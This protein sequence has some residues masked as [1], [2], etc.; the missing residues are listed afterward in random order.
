MV[1]LQRFQ[2]TLLKTI[3]LPVE[4]IKISKKCVQRSGRTKKKV[5][6]GV[7]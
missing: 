2:L 4:S 6:H 5:G 1:S 7:T 3:K